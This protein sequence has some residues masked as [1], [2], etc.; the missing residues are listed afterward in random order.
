MINDRS[1]WSDIENDA[2]VADYMGMLEN[3]LAGRP[4]SKAEHN[5]QLQAL[6]GRGRGSIE[7]KHQNISAVL[8][9]LGETWIEGYKPAFNF[10]TSLVDAVERWLDARP[11][12]F[13]W[14]RMSARVPG[15][16]VLESSASLWMGSPPNLRNEPP[17]SEIE[18]MD[19]I[20]RRF[21]AAER[22]RRNRVLG[23]AGE[24]RVL[25]H[26][27]TQLR[28]AGCPHLA[29]KVRWVSEEDGDGLG[30]DILSFD[31]NGRERL[32]EVKT[33]NGWDRTPFYISRNECEVA[34]ER[35]EDWR[36][37]RLWD[38]ARAPKGFEL[39]PPLER[40]LSLTATSF[41]AALR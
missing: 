2:I 4:Y 17:P 37:I 3:D 28:A 23:K 33:T 26:E 1:P 13:A 21:D 18:Q 11:G 24:E 5:R 36:L 31:V 25:H 32:I 34:E 19:R 8:K 14:D 12:W 27:L 39:H 6:I 41:L 22:D 29:A 35:R 40:H 9:G 10:Q 20:A 15:S 16:S 7:Y 38:F 30:Y